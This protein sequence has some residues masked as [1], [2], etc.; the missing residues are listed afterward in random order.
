MNDFEMSSAVILVDEA[1]A[2]T[3]WVGQEDTL[4]SCYYVIEP[5][6]SET[7]LSMWTR[8]P[9][10]TIVEGPEGA[11]MISGSY[12]FEAVDLGTYIATWKNVGTSSVNLTYA[13]TLMELPSNAQAT[14]DTPLLIAIG[15]LGS[16]VAVETVVLLRI[17]R[18][19][20][21]EADSEPG[22]DGA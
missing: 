13:V 7:E 8:T 5:A 22:K 4:I 1:F 16:I 11:G 3:I 19:L 12:G 14:T 21:K 18:R 17:M 15:A 2:V 6:T 10:G 20:K 9:N